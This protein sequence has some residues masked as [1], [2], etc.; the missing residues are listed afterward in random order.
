MK[1]RI[2]LDAFDY[3]KYP[4]GML[5]YFRHFGFHFNKKACAEAIKGL[6]RL[7]PATAKAEPIEP[8]GKEEI[9]Q[10]LKKNGIVLKNNVMY[11]FVWVYNMLM[12]DYWQ[13]A[14]D[15]EAHL[16]RAVKDMIDDP[17]QREGFIFNRWVCDRMFN[18]DPIEWSDIL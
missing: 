11:D 8:T 1:D 6:R 18:G 9:E 17:D 14:I 4:E 12:S 2:S 15:D 7:N 10:I 16:C 5:S 13:S 3:G